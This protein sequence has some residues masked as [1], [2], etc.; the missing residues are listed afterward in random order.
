MWIERVFELGPYTWRHM[1]LA[2][3]NV[4]AIKSI[5]PT[6]SPSP[7]NP[8]ASRTKTRQHRWYKHGA[9]NPLR[10][11]RTLTSTRSTSASRAPTKTQSSTKRK[12][13]ETGNR[14]RG[15]RI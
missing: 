9:I 2:F 11:R 6:T 13:I 15:L 1:G 12:S 4:P 5:F 3:F 10:T 8:R 7:T 14:R